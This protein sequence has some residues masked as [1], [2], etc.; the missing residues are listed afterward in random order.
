MI[1]EYHNLQIER[2]EKLI[3]GYQKRLYKREPTYQINNHNT[4]VNFNMNSEAPVSEQTVFRPKTSSQR[5]P[6]PKENEM[7]EI[8][9]KCV[10]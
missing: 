6:D 3:K 5:G 8:F 2:H 10:T 4:N 9:K 1:A 7:L